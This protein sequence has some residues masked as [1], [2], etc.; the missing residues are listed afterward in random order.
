MGL[1]HKI[2]NEFIDKVFAI[3]ALTPQ[4][5]YQFLTKRPQRMLGYF[6]SDPQKRI[7]ALI[8]QP[9]WVDLP[10]GRT[11]PRFIETWPLPNVW[12]GVTCE[13]QKAADE[14]IPLLL[15]T[16]AAVRFVSCEP[17]LGAVMFKNKLGWESDC[18]ECGKGVLFDE[19]GCCTQCGAEAVQYGI[20]WVIVG[21]ESGPGARPM[22]PDWVRSLRDQCQ[23][24]GVALHFK[25]WGEWMPE[26]QME[27]SEID[28]LWT[29]SKKRYHYFE[30]GCCVW[31]VGKKKA[32][33]MLGG[34]EWMEF[35]SQNC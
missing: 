19:D 6:H 5:S 17:L 1:V 16:P 24:A 27:Q 30:D 33:R 29:Y 2:P 31:H 26:D 10:P 32:G 22:H 25:Q 18:P 9:K 11:F 3:C 14:R 28:A 13:N 12:L 35:P 8:D 21:G 15:Q 34:R 23:A 20:D 4:H 7:E